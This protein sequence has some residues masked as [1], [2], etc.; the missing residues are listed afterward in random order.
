[1]NDHPNGMNINDRC[2][3]LHPEALAARVVETGAHIGLADGDGV[4]SSPLTNRADA[5]RGPCH[6]RLRA[7]HEIARPSAQ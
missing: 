3:A 7:A 4:A 6:G 5:H 2:G 1:M